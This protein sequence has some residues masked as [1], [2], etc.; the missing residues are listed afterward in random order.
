[1]KDQAP[2][3]ILYGMKMNGK[4]KKQHQLK[5]KPKTKIEINEKCVIRMEMV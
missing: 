3:I 5:P 2:K 1:M 4:N